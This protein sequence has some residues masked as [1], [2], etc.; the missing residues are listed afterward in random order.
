[1]CVRGNA[2]STGV[3]WFFEFHTNHSTVKEPENGGKT[4]EFCRLTS[5]GAVFGSVV[6]VTRRVVDWSWLTLIWLIKRS[7]EK[8][9][10]NG[11]SASWLVLVGLHDKIS[12]N[13]NLSKWLIP[14]GR[15]EPADLYCTDPRVLPAFDRSQI[16]KFGTF[17]LS[18]TLGPR[19]QQHF[20]HDKSLKS[21][22]WKRHF[23]FTSLIDLDLPRFPP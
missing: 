20:N 23:R 3:C 17:Q 1:M 4:S 12:F 15:C 6:T 16:V 7:R 18:K 22:D 19:Q 2:I 9:I 8:P 11:L 10:D 5:S 14:F 21:R 13:Q